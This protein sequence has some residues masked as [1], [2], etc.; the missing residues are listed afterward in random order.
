MTP[1]FENTRLINV[2]KLSANQTYS[3]SLALTAEDIED[4]KQE[5]GLT[6]LRKISF[7]GILEPNGQRDWEL[8]AKLGATAVQACV[9]S[10]EPVTTRIDEPVE[11]LYLHDMP[12]F[13]NAEEEIEMPEDERIE[14]L[15]Q[16][17][18]LVDVFREALVLALPEYPRAQGA[19]I[20]QA[21]FA[22]QGITPLKD[23]DTLPFAGLAALK[24]KM[25][26]N[27]D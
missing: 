20:E 22:E 9:V 7:S 17:I 10:L 13:A 2:S 19:T 27:D 12:E 1:N 4:I 14:A 26:K 15:G 8:K 11:R 18:S 24:E 6:A 23:E 16:Q 5:L 25:K 21:N 3:V